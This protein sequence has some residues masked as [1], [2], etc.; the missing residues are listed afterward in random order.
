MKVSFVSVAVDFRTGLVLAV[1]IVDF[2]L[3][4][5]TIELALTVYTV[6]LFLI[7]FFAD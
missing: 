6:E 4:V 1:L 7:N 3:L 5:Y 2:V